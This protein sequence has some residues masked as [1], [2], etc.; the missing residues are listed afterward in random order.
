MM[1]SQVAI[2]I[3]YLIL[4]RLPL[5]DA[6]LFR[7]VCSQ[8]KQWIDN[9]LRCQKILL[10]DDDMYHWSLSEMSQTLSIN[11][12][13]ILSNRLEIPED[14]LGKE[15]FRESILRT[16]PSI[17]QLY[18]LSVCDGDEPV[19]IHYVELLN[20]WKHS[21][22]KMIV[23][24]VRQEVS[25]R[26]FKALDQCHKLET[27]GVLEDFDGDDT[28]LTGKESFLTCVKSVWFPSFRWI[29]NLDHSSSINGIAIDCMSNENMKSELSNERFPNLQRLYIDLNFSWRTDQ[30]L[31]CLRLQE[32]AKLRHE[33]LR[34]FDFVFRYSPFIQTDVSHL[35]AHLPTHLLTHLHLTQTGTGIPTILRASEPFLNSQNPQVPNGSFDLLGISTQKLL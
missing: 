14:N 9:N 17:E 12:S 24:N 27:F 3:F 32:L 6:I 4:K 19:D 26:F 29:R 21:L 28:Y 33:H 7:A 22:K 25:E 23:Q 8:W 20:G 2:D 11:Y 18:L 34:C 31:I 1:T 10:I 13:Q 35:L 30:S 16:F 5:Q 15:C